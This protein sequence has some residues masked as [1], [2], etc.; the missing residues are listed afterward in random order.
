MEMECKTL[1]LKITSSK[2]IQKLKVKNKKKRPYNFQD[3]PFIN[4]I[5]NTGIKKLLSLL[6]FHQ[7]P[8]LQLDN[9][10]S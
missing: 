8:V 7:H 6:L 9:L 5:Y 1:N 10:I 3:A 2:K 4:I